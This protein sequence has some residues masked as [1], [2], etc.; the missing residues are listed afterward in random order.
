MY[1]SK[2]RSI[3]DLQPSSECLQGYLRRC[4][5]FIRLCTTLL[6]SD[7]FCLKPTL[8]GWIYQRATLYPEK[9]FLQMPAYYFITCG[10]TTCT[11][12]CSFRYSDVESAEYCKCGENCQ[13][14]FEIEF[15]YIS[16][17]FY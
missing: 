15:H 7:L 9:C 4:Y 3:Q 8:F 6:K 14:I 5:Y 13:N 11:R 12:K 2:K 17:Y 10:R 1:T 16:T